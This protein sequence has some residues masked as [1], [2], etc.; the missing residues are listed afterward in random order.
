MNK[1]TIAQ[2]TQA[3]EKRLIKLVEVMRISG[4][5]RA[6]IYEYINKG[7]FP[8]YIKVGSGTFWEYNEVQNWIDEKL[9]QRTPKQ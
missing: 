4:L 5:A 2:P 8:H 6:T 3:L 9:A 1:T 7:M